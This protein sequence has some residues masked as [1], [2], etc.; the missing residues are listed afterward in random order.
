LKW[1]N[2]VLSEG[3]TKAQGEREAKMILTETF[4]ILSSLFIFFPTLAGIYERLSGTN[5]VVTLKKS[6]SAEFLSRQGSAFIFIQFK[7]KTG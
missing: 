4:H 2:S 6:T 1:K 3:K 7:C 5:I